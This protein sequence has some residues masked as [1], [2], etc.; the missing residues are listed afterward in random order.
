M[1]NQQNVYRPHIDGLRAIA[2]S[3]VVLYHAFPAVLPGG[4]IGVDIFFVI[5]GYLI[6]GI[7]DRETSRGGFALFGF[8]VRRVRRIFPALLVVLVVTLGL[9]YRYL[10]PEAYRQLGID[11]MASAAFSANIALMLQSGYFDIES[12]KKPLLHLWSLG[13]EEQFYLLWPLVLMIVSRLGASIFRVA[14]FL[15]AASFALNL[16]MVGSQPV[17]TFYLPFTRAFELLAG[18]ALAVGWQWTG[19]GK[20]HDI[21]ALAGI[22]LIGVAALLLDSSAPFPGWRAALPVF[23]AVL[24]IAAP[25]AWGCRFILSSRPMVWVG[26]ISYPHYLWHWP[27]LVFAAMIKTAALTDIE[28]GLI[29]CLSLILAWATYQLIELP[30]RFGRAPAAKVGGLAAGMVMI[31][32]AGIVVVRW[33]GFES[34]LPAQVRE[35]ASVKTDASGW[36]VAECLLDLGHQTT[37]ADTCVDRNKRPMILLWGDSTAGALLPGLRRAQHDREF[38]VAQFT[39]NSCLPALDGP[40]TCRENNAR[41][42]E[43]AVNLDPDIVLLHAYWGADFQGVADL[44]AALKKRTHARI[45]VLGSVPIWRRGLPQEVLLYYLQHQKMIPER[46]NEGLSRNW[47][48]DVM[49]QK[50]A[51]LGTEYISAR[52]VL[53]DASGCLTRLGPT[54]SDL[55]SSDTVHLTEGASLLLIAGLIDKVLGTSA[56]ER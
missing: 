41:V 20:W 21:R 54:A 24:L 47:Q 29:V 12:A 46:S 27:L 26:L 16:A 6:T 55:T 33:N 56:F 31:A 10:L 3:L 17:A 30:I 35:I 1:G 14:F 5:S 52:D 34:R 38:G 9:G 22:S 39:A 45:V 19:G 32:A 13:I 42:L 48:D 43:I 4:F 11:T 15:G 53:C 7:I 37:F 8:Y 23:G 25:G 2:V 18:A 28:R 49:R 36:R 44:I 40:E 50:L 51:P